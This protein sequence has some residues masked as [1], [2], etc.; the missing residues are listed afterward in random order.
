MMKNSVTMILFGL[1]FLSLIAPIHAS[2]TVDGLIEQNIHVVYAIENINSTLY[3]EILEQKIFNNS[4]IPQAIEI[5]F[6][7]QNLENAEVDYD[8]A[9]EIFT[10]STKSIQVEFYL[11]GSDIIDSTFNP[12]AMTET[13]DVETGW[14]KIHVNLTD[15]FSLDFAQYFE[16][17]VSEWGVTNYTINGEIHP[18]YLYDYPDSAMFDPL[19][20]F[21]LPAKAINI[22]AIKDTI[23]FELPIPLEDNL[24]N[25]PFLVLGV[26]I[27]VNIALIAYR[28]MRR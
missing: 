9:K 17:S 10:N 24:I 20:R 26:L 23:I 3:E 7:E 14:R 13:Y 25:S 5:Y 18:T 16:K 6:D 27:L 12:A 19:C 15:G 22:H 21:V 8:P 2:I 4:T 28:K 1:I 11:S